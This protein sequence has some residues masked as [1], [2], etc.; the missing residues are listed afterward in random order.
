M[1]MIRRC[2]LESTYTSGNKH[3][4]IFITFPIVQCWLGIASTVLLTSLLLVCT[5]RVASSWSLLRIT[6]IPALWC[7]KVLLRELKQKLTSVGHTSKSCFCFC[8]TNESC[9]PSPGD[10][11]KHIDSILVCYISHKSLEKKSFPLHTIFPFFVLC[12]TRGLCRGSGCRIYHH[13]ITT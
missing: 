10:Y 3:H 8:Y 6:V 2:R 12:I 4:A 9:V 7:S 1:V 11:L 5:G 13:E